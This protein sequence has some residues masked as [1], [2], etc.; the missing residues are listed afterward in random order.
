MAGGKFDNTATLANNNWVHWPQ[1]P[2]FQKIGETVIRVEVWVMQKS[3]GAIQMTYQYQNLNLGSWR[4]DK[5]WWPRDPAYPNDETKWNGNGRF[6]RGPAMGTAVAIAT[7]GQNQSY[8]WWSEEI[9][10]I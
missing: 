3:T 2:L 1:G 9:E 10:I 5:I 4:A 6:V 7:S 8:F